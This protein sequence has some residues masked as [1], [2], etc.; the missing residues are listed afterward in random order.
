MR[1]YSDY[2]LKV[3]P[4]CR[5]FKILNRNLF[6]C[7][8]DDK[9]DKHFLN[10]INELKWYFRLKSKK[11]YG[12]IS[13]RFFN[14]CIYIIDYVLN[15]PSYNKGTNYSVFQNEIYNYQLMHKNAEEQAIIRIG[16]AEEYFKNSRD[17]IGAFYMGQWYA[18]INLMKV[19]KKYAFQLTGE[20]I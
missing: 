18:F 15:H 20:L 10:E 14:G 16:Y 2:D 5:S 4:F 12:E 1:I 6:G 13:E 8:V 3:Y 7:F 11:I 19:Y 9:I 17:N